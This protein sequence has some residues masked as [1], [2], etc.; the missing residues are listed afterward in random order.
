M[1]S[2]TMFAQ[3]DSI[4]ASAPFEGEIEYETFEN[5]S[6]YML[7]MPNSI[8]FNGVHKIKLIL[9]GDKMH[10]IDETTGCHIIVDNAAAQAIM[11]GQNANK[12]YS[13]ARQS[14]D[15]KNASRAYVHFC[16]Y[17]KTGL[18]M[19][20]APGTQYVLYPKEFSYVGGVKSPVKTYTFEKTNETKEMLGETCP[21][22]SGRIVRDMGGMD[23]TYDLKAWLSPKW[24]AP[25]G[26]NWDI[27]GLDIPNIAL[28]WAYKY[29]GGHVSMMS[30]GELS[31]YVEADVVKITP[32]EVADDEFDIPVDYKIQ[33][34]GTSNAFKM[35]NY[36]KSVKK[37]LI[38]RGVKGGDNSQKSSGV[39]YKTDSE[40]DF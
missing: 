19:S 16:D 21:L 12:K 3:Q 2:L 36:Y 26:Y 6:D 23:Q 15:M 25:G 29:D 33:T 1:C 13:K 38:K 4:Q 5:W 17:T 7:K 20:D 27:F 18:D 10:K 40:W 9:K 8:L 32:R 30:V 22:Y 37:E 24:K 35:L 31:G 34:G 39:H 11:A 28:K 14:K